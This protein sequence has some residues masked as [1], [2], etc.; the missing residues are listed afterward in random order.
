MC[1]LR[2]T[3]RAPI[4]HS[5]RLLRPVFANSAIDV[6]LTRPGYQTRPN[7]TL[8]LHSTGHFIDGDFVEP[9]EGK[10]F[11][12]VSPIDGETFIQ[13]ARGNKADVDKAVASAH[14]AFTSTWSKTSVTERSN[15][16]L[17]IADVIEANL[18]R[19]A[20]VRA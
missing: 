2:D 16:L 3:W 1:S 18:E 11:D 17:K 5:P 10:Y 6:W 9:N 19:L 4:L 7:T 14:A 13:A 20:Q 15:M 12:N 8:S